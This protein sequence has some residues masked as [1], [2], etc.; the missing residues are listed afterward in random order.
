MLVYDQPVPA[1]VAAAA[2]E[3]D[4]EPR[5]DKKG[6]KLSVPTGDGGGSGASSAGRPQRTGR[7][8]PPPGTGGSPTYPS[9]SPTYP[10]PTNPSPGYPSPGS[11]S[12]P[13]S[14][15]PPNYGGGSPGDGAAAISPRQLTTSGSP[16]SRDGYHSTVMSKGLDVARMNCKL[17]QLDRNRGALWG[18]AGGDPVKRWVM[19]KQL[20]K[21]LDVFHVK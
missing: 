7:G 19:E 17:H 18:L 8:Q 11:P 20:N 1:P 15:P 14:P 9:P 10:S 13:T 16:C 4:E 21:A 6:T 5:T 12:P 2:N 3:P